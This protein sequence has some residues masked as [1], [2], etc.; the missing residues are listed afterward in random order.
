MSS[1]VLTNPTTGTP[2]QT[3][4]SGASVTTDQDNGTLYWAF[5][6]NGGSCTDAQLIAGSGGNILAVAHGSQSVANTGVQTIGIVNGLTPNTT[7]QIKFLHQNSL[8]E[9]SAQVSASL[10]TRPANILGQQVSI[11]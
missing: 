11:L 9:N 7:Y 8:A 1:P 2:S 10:T 3:G 6:T 5:V 4:C